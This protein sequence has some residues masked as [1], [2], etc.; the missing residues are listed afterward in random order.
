LHEVLR[1]LL[2]LEPRRLP[3]VDVADSHRLRM[4]F[5][6]HWLRLVR[7]VDG[8]VA[9][10]LADLGRPSQ[11]AR[12]EPLDG[13][14]FVDH[15]LMDAELLWEELVVVLRV[16]DCR[17]EDLQNRNCS[18]TRCVSEYRTRLVNR[19]SADVIHDQT[20]LAW[21]RSNVLGLG[22]DEDRLGIR[23]RAA[24]ARLLRGGIARAPALATARAGLWA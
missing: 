17:L 22:G 7:Q 12:T 3:V 14:T 9:C 18:C 6:T 4:D 20:G 8:D 5:L 2:L 10:A 11:R 15:H 13:R 21:R 1:E 19:L 24:A 16:R 23:P